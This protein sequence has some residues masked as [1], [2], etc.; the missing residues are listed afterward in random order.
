M[1]VL[2]LEAFDEGSDFRR[3]GT[4][5]SAIL[6][7]LGRQRGQ[8]VAAIAEA[9]IQ[10][11]VHRDLAAGGMGDVVEAGGDLLRAPCEFAAGQRFQHQGRDQAI[12]EERDFFGFVVH[13]VCFFSWT[14]AYGGRLRGSM[15]M[16]CGE[17]QAGAAAEENAARRPSGARPRGQ[18]S[19]WQRTPANRKRGAAIQPVDSSMARARWRK[20]GAGA[21]WVNAASVAHN[22]SACARK[23]R[24]QNWPRW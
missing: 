18:P 6:A 12:T 22:A 24:T 7:R 3:D 11:R 2:A 10:Q 23:R 20:S 1:R 21:G 13:G 5:L 16:V 4:G 9:P 19:R 14:S 15:Q 8:A 17:A